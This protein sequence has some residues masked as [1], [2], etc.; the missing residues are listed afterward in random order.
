MSSATTN[1][2]KIIPS[3]LD[4]S[5][6]VFTLP[7]STSTVAGNK[8]QEFI[9]SAE[10]PSDA[11]STKTKGTVTLSI[12]SGPTNGK[13]LGTKT[14]PLQ[15]GIATFKKV[16]FDIAGT[17]TLEATDTA[18]IAATP[19]TFT[20]TATTPKK[21]IFSQQPAAK[22]AT[23]Q[24]FTV[25]VETEDKYGNL[26]TSDDSSVT[27]VLSGGPKLAG[28]DGTTTENIVEGIAA[29]DDLSIITL[30]HYVLKAS[31]PA[32]NLKVTSKGFKIT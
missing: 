25:S 23:D 18:S 6:L 2:F 20:I 7:P 24:T 19:Q 8:L 28:L 1:T 15:K 26:A 21:M 3:P 4:G 29:F 22:I 10:E 13:I 16:S 14:A 31:D 9:V 27:L 30:G 12:T 11:I 5:H 17:Y 32:D